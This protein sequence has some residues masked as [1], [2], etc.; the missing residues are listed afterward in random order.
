M[1]KFKFIQNL[2]ENE[3]FSISQKDRFFKLVSKELENSTKIDQQVIEDI[4]R[5]KEKLELID[6]EKLLIKNSM[7]IAEFS[8]DEFED[9]KTPKYLISK[10]ED[11]KIKFTTN[12][13]LP[14][15][16]ASL[17]SNDYTKSLTHGIDASDIT[18]LKKSLKIEEYDFSLHLDKIREVFNVLTNK[19]SKFKSK[20]P[21]L[22]A[23][24]LSPN[25]Y[26]KVKN[27]ING[28]SWSTEKKIKMYWAHTTILKW[29]K[30]N[31]G[32]A[33]SVK[34]NSLGYEGFY[35][36]CP[37]LNS[38]NP[39][40]SFHDLVLYFK[41]EIH[42]KK[43]NSL[44]K[45]IDNIYHHPSYSY[46]KLLVIENK[47]PNDL[48]FYTDVEKVKNAIKLIFELILEIYDKN[49]NS[50]MSNKIQFNSIIIGKQIIIKIKHVN[51]LF[52]NNKDTLR[53][54]KSLD[55][56]IKEL[57]GVCDLEIEADFSDSNSYKWPLW[58]TF[59][60][61]LKNKVLYNKDDLRINIGKMLIPLEERVGGV[62]YNLIF[63]RGL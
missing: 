21:D 47:I 54:G 56:L 55:N 27:Y 15:F 26:T 2:L 42:I 30:K 22:K 16:L 7:P 19:E 32:K 40:M 36:D 62:Q 1:S 46:A 18:G 23:H 8:N 60:S 61:Y 35:F 37:E 63:N 39:S 29:C 4:K 52:G 45:I 25:I 51:S 43:T 3:K 48:D 6:K 31:P 28:S 38:K 14:S 24:F 34:E 17:N 9:L 57:N 10:K 20:Y 58:T 44:T 11:E 53:I 5:I 59:G 12:D 13:A 33:P 50:S 41:N 49:E